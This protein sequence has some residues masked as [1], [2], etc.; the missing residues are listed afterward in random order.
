[1][2]SKLLVVTLLTLSAL[3][4]VNAFFHSEG[5]MMINHPHRINRRAPHFQTLRDYT[6]S[7]CRE[8]ARIGD[9]HCENVCTESYVNTEECLKNCLQCASDSCYCDGGFASIA[10]RERCGRPPHGPKNCII[11]YCGYPDGPIMC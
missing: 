11:K 6:P 8:Y 2:L 5:L 1:M 4:L 7:E 9:E 3:A 10:H